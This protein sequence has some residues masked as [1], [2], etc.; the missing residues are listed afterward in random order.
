WAGSAGV[1]HTLRMAVGNPGDVARPQS[2]PDPPGVDLGKLA[3]YLKVACPDLVTGS[4]DGPLDGPLVGPLAGEVIAGGKSNLTYRIWAA[5]PGAAVV[6]RR[7][8]LGH[9]LPTAH[10]MAREYRV[11]AA[12]HPTG[13]PV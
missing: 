2:V 10:D 9:V 4:L 1:R 3:E 11:I 8:P 7:P 5:D 6:L 12:L 13:F